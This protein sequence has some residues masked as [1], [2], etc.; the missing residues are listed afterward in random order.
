MVTVGETEVRHTPPPSLEDMDC[1]MANECPKLHPTNGIPSS[2]ALPL[3]TLVLHHERNFDAALTPP[4]I[5]HCSL[6]TKSL[7]SYSTSGVAA[8][9][10]T[11]EL[12]PVFLHLPSLNHT[13]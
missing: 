3:Q 11:N 2:F 1:G 4:A 7:G 8:V 13:H 12:L 5:A 6:T 10:V 9:I